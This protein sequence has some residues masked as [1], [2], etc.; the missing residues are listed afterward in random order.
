MESNS[1]DL[2]NVDALFTRLHVGA[3]DKIVKRLE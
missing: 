1:I 3:I 2:T